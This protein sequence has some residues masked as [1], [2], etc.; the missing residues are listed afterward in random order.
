MTRAL[1]GRR[2]GTLFG[3]FGTI[4]T[5]FMPVVLATLGINLLLLPLMLTDETVQPGIGWADFVTFLVP[6]LMGLLIP[7]E[8][9]GIGV[10]RLSPAATGGAFPL[11]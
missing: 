2:A 10:P 5:D 6:A 9:R 8:R 3:P 7:D 4:T 11:T 1:H